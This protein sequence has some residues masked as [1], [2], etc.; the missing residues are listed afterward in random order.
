MKTID[1]LRNTPRLLISRVGIDGGCG[2]VW[3]PTAKMTVIWSTGG[4]WE[5]VSVAPFKRH[6]I[7][8]W[9][10]MCIIKEMFWKSGDTVVQ[11]H[12]ADDQYVNNVGNCLHLW[13]PT[14]EALPVPP[15]IMVGVRQGQTLDSVRRE[16]KEMY[17]AEERRL[18][19]NHA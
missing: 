2:E 14:A 17:D 4:G 12:P 1:E 11:Y 15:S 16:V 8:S 10:D 9:D 7:P 6:Y 13:R 18:D 19:G 5:H 3:L